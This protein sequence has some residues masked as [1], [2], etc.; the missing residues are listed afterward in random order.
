MLGGFPEIFISRL[1]QVRAVERRGVVR[2]SKKQKGGAP[3]PGGFSQPENWISY[4]A[5]YSKE[6]K[7]VPNTIP[8]VQGLKEIK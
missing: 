1:T 4:S 6:N 7:H 3:N 5:D 2:T 8:L